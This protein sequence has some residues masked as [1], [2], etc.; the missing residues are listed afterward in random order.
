M[1]KA[2]NKTKAA[3]REGQYT[4][5]LHNTYASIDNYTKILVE[6]ML[7]DLKHFMVEKI[8][9]AGKNARLDA[10]DDKIY[11]SYTRLM[12]F[13][14]NVCVVYD[15]CAAVI[16]SPKIK[17]T[18]EGIYAIL[19][20]RI[21]LQTAEDI[22]EGYANN[23][24]FVEKKSILISS[25][26]S[27]G[28]D[29]D[30]YTNLFLSERLPEC[31][32]MA[33]EMF[34][35]KPEGIDFNEKGL[36]YAKKLLY[37]Q[38]EHLHDSIYRLYVDNVK[39][40]MQ[41]LN[42]IDSR[43]AIM[44]YNELLEQ[45]QEILSSIVR[46]Q[47]PLLEKDKCCSPTE[48]SVVLKINNLLK[49]SFEAL[50]TDMDAITQC[51]KE[52]KKGT[53]TTEEKAIL[54][55]TLKDE[56]ALKELIV[57]TN[58]EGFYK[59]LQVELTEVYRALEI[60]IGVT[61]ERESG[62]R[63]Y[64]RAMYEVRRTIAE[65]LAISNEMIIVFKKIHEKAKQTAEYLESLSEPTEQAEHK[66]SL[67]IIKGISE[68]L[69]IKIDSI[70]ENRDIFDDETK[71]K[72]ESLR[73]DKPRISLLDFV[74]LSMGMDLSKDIDLTNREQLFE[75]YRQ[76]MQKHM[77]QHQDYIHKKNIAYKKD[78]LLFEVTTYEEILTY[79]ISRMRDT[80]LEQIKE[81]VACA[82]EAWTELESIL[83]KNYVNPIEP[84]PHDMFNGKEHEVLVAEKN[85][86]FKKGEIIKLMNCGYKQN[87][88]ILLRA[89]VVAAT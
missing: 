87:E 79:S 8:I 20:S 83:I 27:F 55:E 25:I 82:D 71:H 58:Y 41:K 2:P 34:I 4:K 69:E 9:A 53:Q 77:Q 29:C 45:E 49:E 39:D 23:P 10:C 52:S 72:I 86:E 1:S 62:N 44:L 37:I 32:L 81:F 61:Y 15:E 6:S 57:S 40:S 78:C 26:K 33:R 24:I 65:N 14:K 22:S 50:T 60:E 67:A 75:T 66:D 68:T 11:D 3:E 84:E 48:E 7:Y 73:P 89:N 18:I 13:Y 74:G 64:A 63:L 56:K 47:L 54:F 76:K 43:K 16:V 12:T 88:V 35:I 42:D 36:D 5:K 80:G 59:S 30:Y 31:Q 46:I 51:V 28:N 38:E 19:K 17:S 70:N 85:P 21:S